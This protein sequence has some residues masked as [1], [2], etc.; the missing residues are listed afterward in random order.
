MPSKILC[1]DTILKKQIKIF[2]NENGFEITIWAANYEIA[3]LY[4]TGI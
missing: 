1:T 4:I 2:L 3:F